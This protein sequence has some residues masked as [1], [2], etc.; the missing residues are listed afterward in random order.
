MAGQIATQS[1][2]QSD[3]E[4]IRLPSGHSFRVLRWTRNLREVE[5][6]LA[7]DRIECI[8]GEGMHWHYHGEMELTVFAAGEGTRFVGDHIGQFA[9]GDVVLLG[10]KL[11]HYWHTQGSS[12]GLSVQW[13]FPFGHAFWSFPETSA[14]N[15]LFHRAGRGIQFTGPTA[16]SI[17]DGLQQLV[18]SNGTLRLGGL[19]RLLGLMVDAPDSNLHDLSTRSFALA[20]SAIHQDV[21][22]DVMRHLMVNFRDEVR[23]DE[24][25]RIA[26]MS[27]PT[28][29]RQFKNHSGKT[30]SDFITQIRLQAACRELVETDRSVLEIALNCG[31]SH[32]SFFNR[33]F[34]RILRRN[35]TDYRQIKRLRATGGNL[36]NLNLV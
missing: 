21:M 35:P 25:L 12:A 2:M 7:P 14:C 11:P 22:A 17:H 10:S 3:R 31:C 13:S 6:V 18:V 4:Q 20:D 23:L 1:A 5:S 26:R 16:E 8:T 33:I 36:S 19:L 24:V 9:A 28:F 30:F 29:A 27:K 32:I 15:R 34:R